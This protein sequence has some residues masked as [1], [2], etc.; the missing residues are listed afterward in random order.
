M[1][2]QKEQLLAKSKELFFICF[3]FL[4]D[5]HKSRSHSFRRRKIFSFPYGKNSYPDNQYISF[6]SFSL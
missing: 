3:R 2:S 1:I 6:R 5:S 4:R